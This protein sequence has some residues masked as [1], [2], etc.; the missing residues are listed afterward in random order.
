MDRVKTMLVCL[1]AMTL[2]GCGPSAKQLAE[3]QAKQQAAKKL[4]EEQQAEKVRQNAETQQAR[5][6][7]REAVAAMEVCV[8]NTSYI[9]FREK[10]QALETCYI[11]NQSSLMNEADAFHQLVKV[12]E[13]TD[14][15]WEF[16]IQWPHVSLGRHPVEQWNAMLIINPAVAE[17]TEPRFDENYEPL[18]DFDPEYYVRRGLTLISK[19]CDQLLANH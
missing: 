10:K 13:A 3:Q 5:Q 18:P 11:A 12:M 6:K 7:F 2:C 14:L 9:E 16:Q 17:T 19:Q 4:A 15:I 8:A 1:F